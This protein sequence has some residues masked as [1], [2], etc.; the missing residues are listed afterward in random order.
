MYLSGIKKEKVK[1]SSKI[2]GDTMLGRKDLKDYVCD[3]TAGEKEP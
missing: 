3:Y 1:Y 2:S